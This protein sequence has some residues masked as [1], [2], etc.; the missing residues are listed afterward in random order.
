[1]G[2]NT[3]IWREHDHHST[4]CK[5][6][7]FSNTLRQRPHSAFQVGTNL[8][9]GMNVL[10]WCLYPWNT[11]MFFF[12]LIQRYCHIEVPS[13]PYFLPFSGG[14]LLQGMSVT[15]QNLINSTQIHVFLPKIPLMCPFPNHH[16]LVLHRADQQITLQLL[17]HFGQALQI[18]PLGYGGSPDG[19]REVGCFPVDMQFPEF[20]VALV[21][22]TLAHVTSPRV[23][24]AQDEETS[25]WSINM[26]ICFIYRDLH[27]SKPTHRNLSNLHTSKH[28]TDSKFQVTSIHPF[29]L[30]MSRVSPQPPRDVPEV[31]CVQRA[32]PASSPRRSAISPE[33]PSKVNSWWNM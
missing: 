27:T 2:K 21:A 6:L 5:S 24:R 4:N 30:E 29:G 3:W 18:L 8:C 9:H 22:N 33:K 14:F 16:D 7:V 23:P 28:L 11:C 15:S 25:L 32:R 13:Y 12:V 10:C 26:Y 20:L 31:A 17:L 1:M 19:N